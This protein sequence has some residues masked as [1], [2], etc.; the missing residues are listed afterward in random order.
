MADQQ[1]GHSLLS[2]ELIEQF[3]DLLLNGHIQSCGRLVGNQ[4]FG[5][6]GEC[7]G[8]HHPLALSSGE[9]VWIVFDASFRVV[10]TNPLKK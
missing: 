7:H 1:N 3:E 8:D 6:T 2:L 4:E 9:L 5:S 10:N